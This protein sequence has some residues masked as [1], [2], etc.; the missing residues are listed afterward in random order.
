MARISP[1]RRIAKATPTS[2]SRTRTAWARKLR[3]LESPSNESVEDWSRDGKYIA[4]LFGKDNLQ[5]IYALPLDGLKPGKPFP[6]VQGQYQK[7]EAQFSKDGKWL[8]YVSDEN[9]SGKFEVYVISFPAGDLKQQI[10]TD[11]GGQPRWSWDGKQIHYR[12]LDNRFM[13]V[14]LKLGAT[15][16]HAIPRSLSIT[17]TVQ[18]N[19]R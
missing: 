3:S 19:G 17:P 18:S 9:V 16:E 8:A 10:S 14:D 5:D 13:S 2:T 6:V 4:F 11:G 7:N 15:I 1:S 12:T